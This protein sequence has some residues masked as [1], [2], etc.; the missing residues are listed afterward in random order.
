MSNRREKLQEE[1][2]F[3]V[4]KLVQENP[5]ITQRELAERLG[6]SLGGVNYC[7]KALAAKGMLKIQNFKN[8]NNK[9]AYMYLLTPSGITAKAA[10]AA[11]FLKR[12]IDEYEVLAA[13]IAALEREVAVA[14]EPSDPG[15]TDGK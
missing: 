4:L 10:L 5:G 7:M 1:M 14:R 15:P 6:V 2:H 11:R 3:G 13:E 9:L 12:K 8:S